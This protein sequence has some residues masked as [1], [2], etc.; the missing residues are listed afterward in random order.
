MTSRITPADSRSYGLGR[1]GPLLL[2]ILASCTFGSRPP[3][4]SQL[5]IREIQSRDYDAI[6]EQ[7]ALRAVIAAL[8]DE[9]YIISTA[10]H[11]LGLVTGGLEVR[12]LDKWNRFWGKNT[13]RTTRRIEASATVHARD[14]RT[15]VRIN[16]VAKA[17][18]NTGGVLWSE[19]ITDVIAYQKLF[20]KI[21]KSL[22]LAREKV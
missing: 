14:D 18:T 22:F 20:E 1:L 16:I 3:A 12:D 21:D 8:Q 10:N 9:G 4:M 19:P 11:Q 2:L 17:M 7:A 6:D 5:Q 15:R 13:Y